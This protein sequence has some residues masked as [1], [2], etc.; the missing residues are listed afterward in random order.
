MASECMGIPVTAKAA[1]LGERLPWQ[2]ATGLV[3]SVAVCCLPVLRELG[4][5]F[6]RA[7]SGDK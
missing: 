1:I 7:L 3:A 5:A 2:V 6:G 4:D